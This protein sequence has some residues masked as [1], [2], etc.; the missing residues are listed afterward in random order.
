MKLHP[1]YISFLGIFLIPYLIQGQ[2]VHADFSNS[3]LVCNKSTLQIASLP[4]FGILDNE[5]GEQTCFV[6]NK[7]FKETNSIWMRWRISNSGS[8]NFTILPYDES[9]DIDFV[10]F[11]LSFDEHG[12]IT[13]EAIRC[14]RAGPMLFD[15]IFLE[16]SCTGATGLNSVSFNAMAPSGCHD[17]SSNFLQEI[18]AVEGEFYALLINN[19]HSDSGFALH[20]GGDCNFDATLNGC[21]ITGGNS[22]D[23]ANLSSIS[24][25]FPNPAQNSVS[26][27]LNS[28]KTESMLLQIIHVSGILM[29]QQKINVE[30]GS[31]LIS[32]DIA[33]LLPSTYFLKVISSESTSIRQFVKN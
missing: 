28:T 16:N 10:L 20:F 2:V 15:S 29:S 6:L 3:L 8:L 12:A 32:V 11:K 18:T 4:G 27:S 1:F 33:S 24:E 13:K 30:S 22:V 31:S 25:L 5:T 17:I 7:P 9:D 23:A 14:M 21:L 19:Y 26:F